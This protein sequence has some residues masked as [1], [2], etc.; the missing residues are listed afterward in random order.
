MKASRIVA[1]GEI[2][3]EEVPDP[4][5]GKDDV[6]I[7]TIF[8]A[9]CGSDIYVL[10]H[11]PAAAYPMASGTT[12]HEMVG[13]V[14]A[15]GSDVST[16]E[17][18]DFV[19]GLA[20]SH[21]AMCELF[22]VDAKNAFKL[23]RG[24]TLEEYLMAQQ[25]GTVIYSCDRLP[26]IEGVTAI[27]I[28]QGSA[29]LF[30]DFMLKQLGAKTVI[31]MDLEETRIALSPSFGADYAF[32]NRD[33]DP[34]TK[35]KN[36]TSGKMADLVVEATGEIDAI[37]LAAH[38]I[39]EQGR[40]FFFGIPHQRTFLFDYDTFFR[41]YANTISC[42]GAMGQ[43]DKSMFTR[44]LS[45]I[46][47]GKVPASELTTHRFP[48]HDLSSAYKLAKSREDGAVKVIVEMPGSEVYRDR[49]VE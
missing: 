38:L 9:T 42:S 12:G 27:V 8:L 6:V 10:H 32:L 46:A 44:A 47:D 28:G 41:K 21:T 36:L 20:P 39:R 49:V 24:R 35:V 11:A 17:E 34:V 22:R 26:D 4:S 40:L 25:L 2:V 18:G 37:N 23:P 31:A 1:P 29:G 30:F 16:V 15:V 19:L 33:V 13:I 5:P 45:L 7:R 48:F 43:S 3:F 14:A